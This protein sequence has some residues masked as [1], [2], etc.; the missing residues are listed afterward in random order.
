VQK[1]FQNAEIGIAKPGSSD[2][3]P[4][5]RRNRLKRLHQD[6]PD[7]NTGMILLGSNF[8]ASHFRV[9]T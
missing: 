3:F 2:A 9:L 8:L 4:G 7:V 6:Q 1:R 5:V